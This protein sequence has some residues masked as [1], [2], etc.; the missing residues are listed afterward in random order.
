[1]VIVMVM[2]GLSYCCKLAA[3]DVDV[4]VW[5]WWISGGLAQ[6]RVLVRGGGDAGGRVGWKRVVEE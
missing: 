4:S 2:V 3:A 1:V 5:I 6:L